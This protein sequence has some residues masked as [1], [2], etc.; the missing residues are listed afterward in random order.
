ME[1][2]VRMQSAM[3]LAPKKA[4]EIREI[5]REP[6]R[7][8]FFSLPEAEKTFVRK[9]MNEIKKEKVVDATMKKAIAGNNTIFYQKRRGSVSFF[10][11]EPGTIAGR[12]K[13]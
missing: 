4:G 10:W 13:K 8:M 2:K 1:K 7:V 6:F 12:V 11:L 3:K 9:K 5:V